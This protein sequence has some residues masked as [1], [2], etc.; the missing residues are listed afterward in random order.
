LRKLSVIII[1]AGPYGLSVAAHLAEHGVEHRIFGQPMQFWSQIAAAGS[2][3]FLKSY[4]FGTNISSPREGYSFA[5]FSRP[6]GLETF[7]PCSIR[8]FADYGCWFQQAVVP[9]AEPVDVVSVDRGPTDFL[10]T[11]SNEE[12]LTCSRVIVATGLSGFA[13]LPPVLATLNPRIALHSSSVISFLALRGRRVAVVGAGQSALEAAALLHE[14]GAEPQLLVREHAISWNRRIYLDRTLWQRLRS[15]ITGLGTGPK[16]WLLTKFPGLVHRTPVRCRRRLVATHL[17]AEGAWWLRERVETRVPISLGTTVVAAKQSGECAVLRLR[18][19]EDG[20]EREIEVD[21]VIAGCGFV[22]DADRLGFLSQPLRKR[23]AR[24]EQAPRLNANF[25]S[26]VPGLYF[27][28]PSSALSFGPLFR[29]VVGAEYS[30]GR[31]AWH[32]KTH[33]RLAA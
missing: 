14:A 16:A 8:Q 12:Q 31:I 17:P 10:V 18:D 28:G 15:P 4:C 22:V 21:A 30:A 33:S 32:L 25:E 24:I 1:G 27:V 11:M 3:R 26:S 20:G 13:Y 5:D 29:F 19:D 9:W 23:I 2:A 6:R 7:E